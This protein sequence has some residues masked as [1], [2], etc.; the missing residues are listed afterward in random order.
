MMQTP[1]IFDMS[2]AKVQGRIMSTVAGLVLLSIILMIIIIPSVLQDT[3]AGAG[4]IGAAIGIVVLIMLHLTVLLGFL[5]AIR[6]NK[7][8]RPAGKGLNILLGILL[9]LF[10]LFYM[11]GAFAFFETILFVSILMFISAFCDIV[12][13]LITFIALFLK[14]KKSNEIDL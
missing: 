13:A 9:V 11:D 1:K 3:S 14:P 4:P 12:A 5:K 7:R 6:R 8:G 2:K 10:G